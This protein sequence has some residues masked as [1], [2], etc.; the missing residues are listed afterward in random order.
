MHGPGKTKNSSIMHKS[1]VRERIAKYE[2]EMHGPGKTEN[3]SIM[4]K[5]GVR[6]RDH[7]AKS[8]VRER[9]AKFAQE[10]TLEFDDQAEQGRCTMN[11]GRDIY[12]GDAQLDSQCQAEQDMPG[13]AQE[14][15]SQA[16]MQDGDA[17]EADAKLTTSPP[18]AVAE[19]PKPLHGATPESGLWRGML[20]SQ[21]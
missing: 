3:S 18:Q 10:Q 14:S 5:S 1:G 2:T 12:L 13:D 6:E 19:I 4:Y 11:T 21:L 9:D 16:E 17:Q 8:G 15:T 7:L 20:S